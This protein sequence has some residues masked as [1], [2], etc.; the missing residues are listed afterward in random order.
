MKVIQ[1]EHNPV[2]SALF[3]SSFTKGLYCNCNKM[4]TEVIA[5]HANICDSTLGRDIVVTINTAL[6][7]DTMNS[8]YQ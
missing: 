6:R 2:N 4:H 8:Q 1:E 7:S 3:N 5:I